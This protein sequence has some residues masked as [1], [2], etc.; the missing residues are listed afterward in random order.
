M[1]HLSITEIPGLKFSWKISSLQIYFSTGFG[2]RHSY[3]MKEPYWQVANNVK[4]KL[5]AFFTDGQEIQLELFELSILSYLVLCGSHQKARKRKQNQVKREAS[6]L[7]SLTLGAA[8]TVF[9]KDVTALDPSNSDMS[10]PDQEW[11]L[12]QVRDQSLYLIPDTFEARHGL[13]W[14]VFH[15]SADSDRV[16][17]MKLGGGHP[18]VHREHKRRPIDILCSALAYV[19]LHKLR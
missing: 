18:L 5:D 9:N 14:R 6:R 17:E 1:T 15:N 4:A 12:A 11:F 13:S 3:D 2:I 19:R 10:V 16:R 8:V 7:F